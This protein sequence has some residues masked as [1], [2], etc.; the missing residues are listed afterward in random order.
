M[1]VYTAQERTRDLMDSLLN[2]KMPHH[3]AWELASEEWAFLPSE[4]DDQDT[5]L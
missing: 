1:W 5:G 2:Q 4:E 3:E